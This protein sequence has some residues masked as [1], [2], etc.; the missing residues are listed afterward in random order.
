MVADLFRSAGALGALALSLAS[1]SAP[2]KRDIK[3]ATTVPASYDDVWS[4]VI[5][6]FS[7]RGWTIGNVEKDSGLITTDWMTLNGED[8]SAFADCGGSGVTFTEG[9]QIKFNV[10]I[11]DEDGTVVTVDTFFRALR[12]LGE[13]TAFVPC[14]SKGTV[15]KLVHAEVERRTAG[16]SPRVAKVQ[17]KAEIKEA[18]QP[19]GYFCAVSKESGFCARHKH[20]CTAARDAAIATVADL[21][22]CTLTESAHCFDVDGRERCFPSKE[23]CVSRAGE[24]CRERK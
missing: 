11:R 24:A 20:D 15:E 21:S 8:E 19:R 1:A 13:Q 9:V 16:K 3:K 12:S 18:P 23:L 4:A 5:D 17:A 7:E 2:A 10:R 22:E 14:Q 6:V